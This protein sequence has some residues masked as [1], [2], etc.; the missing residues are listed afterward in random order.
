MPSPR[1]G[2]LS[3]KLARRDRPFPQHTE[4][5]GTCGLALSLAFPPVAIRFPSAKKANLVATS[6][7]NED[8]DRM[9]IA[10]AGLPGTGKSAIAAR[11]AAEL[12]AVALSKDDVRG[13]LFPPP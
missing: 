11:L 7:R 2:H 9:L 4:E 6:A 5:I 12:D 3:S 1:R 10:M 8:N 13:A